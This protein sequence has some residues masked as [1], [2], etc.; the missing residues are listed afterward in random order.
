VVVWVS[1]QKVVDNDGSHGSPG[2]APEGS[3]DFPAAGLYPIEI[4]WFNGDWTDDAGNHGGANINFTSDGGAGIGGA[5]A[6]VPV[7]ALYG[8]ADVSKAS[9]P[10]SSVSAATGD[11]GTG[12][13]GRYWQLPVGSIINIL[14]RGGDQDIG[15]KTI[16]GTAPSGYFT[17][18]AVNYTGN[19]LTPILEWL[20]DDSASYRGLEGNLDDGLI[21]LKGYIAIPEAGEHTFSTPSDDGSIV[22]VGGVKVVDNDGSH[23]SPG[24]APDGTAVFSSAGLY[25]IEIAWFNGDWTDDAGNHGGA[26]I[27]FNLN[28]A[29]VTTDM[30]YPAMSSFELAGT[31]IGIEGDPVVPGS[32]EIRNP[33]PNVY[34]VDVVAGG[35]DIWGNDD[36]GHFVYTEWTGDFDA[37]VEVTRLDVI[38]QWS[39]AGISVRESLDTGSRHVFVNVDSAAETPVDGTATGANTY[40]MGV[41]TAT[42]G[43]T[44]NWDANGGE[45]RANVADSTLPAWIRVLR[46]GDEFTAFRSSD[47]A[48][49]TKMGS[50]VQEY[51]D[52]VFVALGTTSHN[53]GGADLQTTAHYRSFTIISPMIDVQ[54]PTMGISLEG[55]EVIVTWDKGELQSATSVNGPWTAVTVI[56]GRGAAAVPATSPHTA[57]TS[58]AARFYRVVD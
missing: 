35:S 31:D 3:F 2:P 17:S 38:N 46:L 42:D 16:Q 5:G 55:G 32:S 14:D 44:G 25:P 50:I 19:D 33:Y 27:V 7:A 29:E 56:P 36:S 41:R 26:N 37:T 21:S 53:N 51:P 58:G 52:S 43:G 13:S 40:E 10:A 15:L 34:D 45:P 12:L 49:W 23:G 39:K 11:A 48:E 8:T 4:A 18:T 24:P 6:T 57:D 9:V 20:G 30:L 22:W 28:G 54:P 47:G 1:G